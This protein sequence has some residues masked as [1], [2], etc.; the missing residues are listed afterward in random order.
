KGL[1]KRLHRVRTPALIVWGRQD[2]LAPVT[3]AD[4]FGRR[5]PGSRVHVVDECG[6]LPAVEQED[7]TYRVISEFLSG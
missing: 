7:E 2:R 5:L 4:E 3:Y 6:H 1:S